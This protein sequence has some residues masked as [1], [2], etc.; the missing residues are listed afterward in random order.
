MDG[1][2]F[3]HIN[4]EPQRT[5][6]PDS[7]SDCN[8]VSSTCYTNSQHLLNQQQTD[9]NNCGSFI[10]LA[11]GTNPTTSGSANLLINS[12][13]NSSGH[14]VLSDLFSSPLSPDDSSYSENS[15]YT[16]DEYDES[17]GAIGENEN[18]NKFAPTNSL[19][20]ISTASNTRASLPPFPTLS[21][22]HGVSIVTD[23]DRFVSFSPEFIVAR[24]QVDSSSS[25]GMQQVY[26]YSELYNRQYAQT[27]HLINVPIICSQSSESCERTVNLAPTMCSSVRMVP[28]NSQSD[29]CQSYTDLSQSIASSSAV[30]TINGY[31][32]AVTNGKDNRVTPVSLQ[33]SKTYT[34]IEP[35]ELSDEQYIG[36]SEV[37]LVIDSQQLDTEE[38]SAEMSQSSSED[39]SE[40]LGEIIKKTM[41]ETVTA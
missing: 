15:D 6:I 33:D 25:Y 16:S 27:S 37:E 10:Q 12:P 20:I 9:A 35:V 30:E 24:H 3:N 13:S 38:S 11:N 7:T 41:V 28:Q 21:A 19:S 8:F 26:N 31:L 17:D 18:I 4:R 2:N 32:S 23:A 39:M 14:E 1:S 34:Q 40:N 36:I 29:D 5:E 22:N